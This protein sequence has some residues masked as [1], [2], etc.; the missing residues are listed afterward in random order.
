MRNDIITFTYYA[1]NYEYDFIEKAWGN[2]DIKGTLGNHLKEKWD[3]LVSKLTQA[4]KECDNPF[5]RNLTGTCLFYEFYM[6]LDNRNK[7][8]LNR[9]II[10]K[11]KFRQ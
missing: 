11:N 2:T 7:G 6:M 3:V 8:T 4:R 1:N 9:Y 10:N 5:V